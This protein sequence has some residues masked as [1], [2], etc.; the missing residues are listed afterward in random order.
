VIA[1]DY[2]DEPEFIFASENA[3]YTDEPEFIFATDNADYTDDSSAKLW[4]N[5]FKS[6]C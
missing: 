1:T 3:D 6:Q 4:S 2:T 5:S